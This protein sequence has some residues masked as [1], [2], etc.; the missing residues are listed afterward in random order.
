[1][2]VRVR[3]TQ[4]GDLL[5]DRGRLFVANEAGVFRVPTIAEGTLRDDGKFLI[6]FDGILCPLL[7]HEPRRMR[8][9]DG[10]EIPVP[11]PC[12]FEIL[13]DGASPLVDSLW[14]HVA[15]GRA[16]D[17]SLG[18]SL[19]ILRSAIREMALVAKGSLARSIE[20]HLGTIRGE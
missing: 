13:A 15:A 20:R 19:E 6:R 16:G 3:I 8:C 10:L 18:E 17:P 2:A 7:R 9:S 4:A 14:R 5:N 12:Q 11:S 1:M